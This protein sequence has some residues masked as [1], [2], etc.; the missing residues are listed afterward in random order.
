ME[1][2]DSEMCYQCL[3]IKIFPKIFLSFPYFSLICYFCN[4]VSVLTVNMELS[5]PQ[6]KTSTVCSNFSLK[7]FSLFQ[8][9]SSESLGDI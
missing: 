4:S 3:G 5:F 1:G 7:T 9:L 8:D 6:F 2:R